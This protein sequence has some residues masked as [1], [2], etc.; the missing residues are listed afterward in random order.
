MQHLAHTRLS[1]QR[2][3]ISEL[4]NDVFPKHR[5]VQHRFVRAPSSRFLHRVGDAFGA[6]EGATGVPPQVGM[7][8]SQTRTRRWSLVCGAILL[9]SLRFAHH[10]HMLSAVRA[11]IEW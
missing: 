8:M 4:L 7:C 3:V 10:L 1:M 5:L 6:L 9:D 11:N 2:T